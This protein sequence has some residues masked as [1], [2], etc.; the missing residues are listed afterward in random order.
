VFNWYQQFGIKPESVL[1]DVGCCT[2]CP[3]IHFIPFLN[4][5]NFFGFD[6]EP[7]AIEIAKQEVKKRGLSDKNP[8][9]WVTENCDVSPVNKPVDI[10]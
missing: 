9:L 10:I 2:L 7:K 6:K 1:L 3:G 5:G 8:V 4:K